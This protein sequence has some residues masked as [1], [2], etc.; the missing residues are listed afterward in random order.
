MITTL[1]RLFA[2]TLGKIL[3]LSFVVIVGVAFALGDV[4]GNSSFGGVGGANVAKV[5]GT[6]IGV[7]E[8]RDRVRRAYD[9]ARQQQPELTMASFVES[10]GLEGALKDL[11][12]G[13]AFDQYAAAM[14]FGVSKRLV[15]GRIADLPVFAGVSGKF[16]QSQYE[17]FLRDNGLSGTQVRKEVTRQILFEQ[18]V[19][20]IGAMPGI[21]TKMAQPYAALLLEERKGLATFIPASPFAPNAD[22]GDKSLQEYLA[23]NRS[24]YS[25]PERRVLQYALFERSS[26]PVP[27]V[28]DAEIAAD[29]NANAAQYKASETRRFS[30]VIIPSEATAK[31]V[32]AKVRGGATLAAAAQSAGLAASQTAAVTQTAFGALTSPAIAKAAFA[33]RK[34]DLIGPQQGALGW[35]VLRVEGIE[36]IPARTLAQAS[37]EIRTRLAA[38]KANEAVVDYY[39]AVQD[40]VNAGAA[41]NEVATDRKLKIVETPPVLP[42]GRAPGQPAFALSAGLAPMVGQAFQGGSEGETQLA[43]LVENEVFAI[44][45]VKKI[46]PA[47]PP[48]FGEIRG[49]L[50]ADWKLAEGQKIARD[51]ARAIVKAVEGGKSLAAAVSA[52]GSNIGSVQS[53]GGKRADMAR[54]GQSMPPEV[55]LLFSMAAGS[56]K[57]LE[58]PGNRGWMVIALA[59]VTRPDPKAVPAQAV[60]AVAAS[61]GPAFGNELA[62]QLVAEAKRRAGV[63]INKQ[64]IE[65][66]RQELT[67]ATPASE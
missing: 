28:N 34:G 10:G 1:R 56:V 48:P 5:G 65:Q 8:L 37:A 43:T 26:I 29:Y 66:L 14:G 3:T 22:P 52:A 18:M 53:I 16:E 54:D 30:Q 7:G 24:K 44:Y 58:I 35:I 17:K 21:A 31:Q 38:S 57:T 67:G 36:A 49:Q 45:A 13:E 11:V 33:A 64:V 46:L 60:T 41:L 15:D 62:E 59:Q 47:A 19:T 40:A 61:L 6:S 32:A 2:S 25:I 51:K 23:R 12:D 42:S 39:N 20:P 9:Q 55:A 4:T 27:E 50:L 63:V